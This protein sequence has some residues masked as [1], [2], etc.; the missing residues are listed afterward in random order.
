MFLFFSVSLF[1]LILFHYIKLQ[2]VEQGS[3]H[4]DSC[5][6]ACLREPAELQFSMISVSVSTLDEPWWLVENK[7]RVEPNRQTYSKRKRRVCV[8]VVFVYYFVH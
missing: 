7:V 4:C 2:F 3:C 8:V 5:L 6:P 1:T